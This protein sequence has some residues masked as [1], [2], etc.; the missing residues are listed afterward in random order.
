VIVG[1]PRAPILVRALRLEYVTVGWNVVEGVVA[2]AAAA[3]AGSVALLGFGVDSF[4]ESAW[5]ILVWR[6]H[7]G[8]RAEDE[9]VEQVERRA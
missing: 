5:L 4:V 2:L 9:R 6:L 3:A 7:A 1:E 8:R